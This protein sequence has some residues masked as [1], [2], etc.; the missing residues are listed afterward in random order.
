MLDRDKLILG[1]VVSRLLKP[2]VSADY[3]DFLLTFA[4]SLAD[5]LPAAVAEPIRKAG[6]RLHKPAFQKKI[7]GRHVILGHRVHASDVFAL[8]D[9]MAAILVNRYA[10][11]IAALS[12]PLNAGI[13]VPVDGNLR[14]RAL[15]EDL[16]QP[17]L[18][19]L[20]T[21]R[22][23]FG[24]TP[25][26]M[27]AITA[28]SA[29]PHLQHQLMHRMA[30]RQDAP[31]RANA[32]RALFLRDLYGYTPRQLAVALGNR[33]AEKALNEAEEQAFDS[34]WHRFRHLYESEDAI[35]ESV[36]KR[37]TGGDSKAL[38]AKLLKYRRESGG[39]SSDPLG[40]ED[41][42]TA[43]ANGRSAEK[44]HEERVAEQTTHMQRSRA[45]ADEYQQFDD[46]DT[47]IF[48]GGRH[49]TPE[50]LEDEEL[51]AESGVSRSARKTALPWNYVLGRR[52]H[53]LNATYTPAVPAT[54][55]DVSDTAV[56]H[57]PDAASD[58]SAAAADSGGWV[59][60]RFMSRK[61]VRTVEVAA[62][63]A[64]AT[65]I[66]GCDIGVVDASTLNRSQLVDSFLYDYYVPNRP[67]VLRGYT[68]SS[69]LRESW[70]LESLLRRHGSVR[71]EVGEIPYVRSSLIRVGGTLRE[72]FPSAAPE[73]D[74]AL[75]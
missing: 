14:E 29:I 30:P 3:R 34:L 11:K 53:T 6:E 60:P 62:R 65:G 10:P 38:D 15:K 9:A 28:P 61:A 66:G 40:G 32:T 64:G 41:R 42:E 33:A 7:N 37:M 75:L 1:D 19:D 18:L 45:R 67:F 69:P 68:L 74:C 20:V 25:L 27:A 23:K 26:H 57:A 8:S 48:F 12:N 73:A 50:W 17:S 52:A 63:Q 72:S 47:S 35:V 43:A 71:F 24:R 39:F 54:A 49:A 51:E 44:T 4:H 70:T 59:P 16:K 22:D 13:G 36:L 58:N 5:L 31:Q 46:A 21:Q 56:K 55:E 2:S